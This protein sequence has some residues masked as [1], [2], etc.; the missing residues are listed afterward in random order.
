[1][2][3]LVAIKK[4]RYSRVF[5]IG[6]ASTV[7]FAS[8]LGLRAWGLYFLL[9]EQELIEAK[10]VVINRNSR[11]AYDLDKDLAAVESMAKDIESRLINASREA[12]NLRIFYALEK[13]TQVTM[14]DASQVHVA[15]FAIPEAEDDEDLLDEG[16]DVD[17]EDREDLDEEE[18]QVY[19]VMTFSMRLEG[20][21]NQLTD[22]LYKLRTG[23]PFTRLAALDIWVPEEPKRPGVLQAELT[24]EVLGEEGE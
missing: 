14:Q 11:S 19:Q 21:F 10:L 16:V 1:M 18:A 3:I 6:A 5:L 12:Y 8:L 9:E 17:I 7:F 20:S 24:V 23:G 15:L 2:L 13:L 4:I 22:F